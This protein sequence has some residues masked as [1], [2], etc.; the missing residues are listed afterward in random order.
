MTD[1]VR[2][3]EESQ[4]LDSLRSSDFD[5]YSAY[6]EVIDNA[7]QAEA[8]KISIK[9]D[10][11][12][13][14]K[15][16]QIETLSFADNGNGMKPETLQRCLRLGWSSRFND[17]SGIGRFG[18]GMIL[19]A[20]HEVKRVEVYSK[21]KGQ[22]EWLFTYIDLDEIKSGQ[23]EGIPAP[24][25]KNIPKEFS[26]L[27]AGDSGTLVLWKKY[28][29]QKISAEKIIEE[30]H[31]Y[32]GRTFRHFIWNGVD[33]TLNG[34]EVK[35]HDPLFLK[36]DKTK[37][38]E[39][40]VGKAMEDMVI[41]W[42][43]TDKEVREKFG[44]TGQ[45]HI[46][47]SLLP[48]QFRPKQGSG[49]AQLAKDRYIQDMQE[50]VSILREQREVF[51][52]HIPYWPLVKIMNSRANSWPFIEKDRWW[53]CEISF[54]AELDSAFEVKNIKR[55]ANPEVELK[56]T[57]KEMITPTR[58]DLLNE[59][60]EVW[61]AAKDREAQEKQTKET[62]LN[63]HPS[64]P[65]AEK[66]AAKGSGGLRSKLNAD[67]TPEQV[68][69]ELK[70]QSL[71]DMDEKQKQRY[72]ALFQAQDFTIIDNK[73]RGDSFWEVTFGGGKIAMEYNT[74][75]DF[76]RQLR[77]LELKIEDEKDPQAIKE[78]AKNIT[79]LV[80]LLLVSLAKA[81]S[82]FD[83]NDTT[84]IPELNERLNSQWGM[85]LKQFTKAWKE[86]END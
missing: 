35:A 73:W 39:D 79:A 74:S 44:A 72:L 85:L 57:I 70:D 63:R 62:G 31:H 15:F 22:G 59:V 78:N 45:I 38:P 68:A 47:M 75:H 49:G 67:K 16:R 26:D 83:A 23:M 61:R 40:P 76:V 80:N 52:G 48:E 71:A 53:G 77:D 28:D 8:N 54:G 19:G 20:I 84:T 33:I 10:L 37:F 32:I 1:V 17:R 36:T 18:V 11:V 7:I 66:A 6:G 50:G 64:H 3:V 43:I 5:A 24:T 86:N 69:A 34:A 12:S 60:D 42:P 9:F 81:Q 2:L 65:K 51:F 25:Q 21:P 29:R 46:R 55:G 58:N 82:S 14:A 41:E 13:G 27:A 4:A 56:R 30:A